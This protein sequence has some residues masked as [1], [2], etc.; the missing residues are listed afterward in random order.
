MIVDPWM[1]ECWPPHL[2][3]QCHCQDVCPDGT[4]PMFSPIDAELRSLVEDEFRTWLVQ[5]RLAIATSS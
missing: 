2:Q 4:E 3:R 5:R 1:L